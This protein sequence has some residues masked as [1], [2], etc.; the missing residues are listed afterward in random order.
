METAWE[1][2][3]ATFLTQLSAVQ[4]ES[5]EILTR[6]R[7]LLVAADTAGLA[8]VAKREEALIEKLQ[9]CLARRGQL[10]EQAAGEGLPSESI[11]S[12]TAALPD[13]AKREL[14]D[15]VNQA[16]RRTRLLQHHS[17]TNWVLVQ[18][19][20]IHLSQ[21]LEIIATGGQMQPTYERE[22]SLHASGAL[23]DRA[24]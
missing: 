5:L 20:L 21:I 1:S 12:L 2:E 24:V 10:L 23:V 11:R 14:T 15:Q 4:D 13:R 18:R 19:T 16:A 9:G 3:L 7:Q 22:E 8:D 6:K 17:L